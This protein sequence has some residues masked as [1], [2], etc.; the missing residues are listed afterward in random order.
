MGI[1]ENHF[2]HYVGKYVP[3]TEFPRIFSAEIGPLQLGVVLVMCKSTWTTSGLNRRLIVQIS[4]IITDMRYQNL[5]KET[6][7]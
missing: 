7:S 1:I 2:G 5:K 4:T 3:G 6:T